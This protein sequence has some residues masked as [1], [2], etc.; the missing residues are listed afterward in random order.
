MKL[1]TVTAMLFTSALMPMFHP[2]LAAKR[3]KTLEGTKK[4]RLARAQGTLT[5]SSTSCAH[6]F[7]LLV[8]MTSLRQWATVASET[9]SYYL[10]HLKMLELLMRER[11]ATSTSAKDLDILLV[12]YFDVLHSEG[13]NPTA[14]SR[15]LATLLHWLPSLG[16]GIGSTFPGASRALRGWQK[17]QPA[18][19]RQP[20]PYLAML[21]IV[22]ALLARYL[23]AHAIVTLI[24]FSAYLRPQRYGS[25]HFAFW[26]VVLHPQKMVKKSK[27]GLWDE[28]L[29]LN[30]AFLDWATPFLKTLCGGDPGAP[31]RPFTHQ[32]LLEEFRLAA[33]RTRLDRLRLCL[34]SLRHGG[35]SYNVLEMKKSD[36]DIAERGRWLS[37]LSVCRY[38]KASHALA[39]LAKLDNDVIMFAEPVRR[40][41]PSMLNPS[42]AATALAKA[43]L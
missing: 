21:A 13:G 15:T 8:A 32:S 19:T 17:L 14:G 6:L 36:P 1:L 7:P 43:H 2:V 5:L 38:C 26:A 37:L 12:V 23:V 29:I 4:G 39:K 16:C 41:F 34:Y 33:A 10:D 40:N 20:L 22:G 3:I 24:R 30:Y 11:L 18:E 35:A 42:F 9:A 28:N 31:L 25:A 27:G